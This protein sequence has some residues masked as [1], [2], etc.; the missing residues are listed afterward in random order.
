MFDRIE[1]YRSLNAVVTLMREEALAR[2]QAADEARAKRQNWGPLH[3]VPAL[4]KTHSKRGC[5]NH[6][7]ATAL[8]DYVPNMDARGGGASAGCGRRLLLGMT[9]VPPMLADYQSDNPIFG[10]SNNPWDP[11]RTP[12]GSTGGGAAALA[13]GL[14]TSTIGSDIAGSIRVP[15]HL[16]RCLWPPAQLRCGSG[17]W[18][19]PATARRSPG[20]AYG[21]QRCWSAGAIG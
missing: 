20:A 6:S 9:N 15:A 7:W 3:G 21:S 10:R 5:P 14:A 12:G 1:R 16:L 19:H 2:A 11:A 13:A 17:T 18:P 8:K 4:S